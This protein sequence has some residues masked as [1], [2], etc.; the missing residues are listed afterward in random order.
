MIEKEQAD[1][2]VR[3]GWLRI[4]A[5]FESM[6]IVQ[7]TATVALAELIEKLDEDPR[8]KVYK[9]DFSE[10]QRIEKLVKGFD[11]AFSQAVKVE[12]VVKNLDEL[13]DVVIEYGPSSLEILEPKEIKLNTAEAQSVINSIAAM[14]HRFAEAG[15][16][17]AVFVTGKGAN[18]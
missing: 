4:W 5:G 18:Q 13:V 6:A 14:M 9:K 8:V 11:E 7:E 1:V 16:G 17:G 12:F 10:P 15:L 3:E 2:K